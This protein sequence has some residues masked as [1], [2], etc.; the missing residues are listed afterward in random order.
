MGPSINGLDKLLKLPT[1]CGEQNML[2][3]APNIYI[4]KYLEATNNLNEN[5]MDKAKNFLTKG[6]Y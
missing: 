6:K 5:I 4:V 1:G 2:K 3:F